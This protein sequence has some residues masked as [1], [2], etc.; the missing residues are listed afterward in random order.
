[1]PVWPM[2][3]DCVKID[4]QPSYGAWEQSHLTVVPCPWTLHVGAIPVHGIKINKKC[5]AS[6]T[7][8]L[9]N[10][11]DAL[12]RGPGLQ[13]AAEAQHIDRY[14][15]SFNIR[16]KRGG[17]SLSMHALGRAID[18]DA[19]EN[20]QHSQHHLFTEHSLIVIK[21]EA[22]GWVWGGRWSPGSIDAM[23]YQAARV[24]P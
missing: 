23:H 16:P 22:E 5:A 3:S 7:T 10:I 13:K 8:V 15:G 18:F 17:T 4:G 21:F 20:A 12:G 6:L 1:M 14:D 19:G 24:H 2:Q 9:N 11:A